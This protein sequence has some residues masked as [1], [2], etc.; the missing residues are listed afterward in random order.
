MKLAVIERTKGK[1]KRNI[2]GKVHKRHCIHTDMLRDATHARSHEHQTG[3][4]VN[5]NVHDDACIEA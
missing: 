3:P 1:G 4:T 2:D 5:E